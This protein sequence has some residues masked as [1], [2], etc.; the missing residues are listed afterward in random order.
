[1]CPNINNLPMW[2]TIKIKGIFQ[3]FNVYGTYNSYKK[4]LLNSNIV[5]LLCYIFLISL[6]LYKII[7]DTKLPNFAN[8]SFWKH[9]EMN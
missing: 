3:Y 5:S 6:K 7:Y 9:G 2:F 8:F 1:M 4:E